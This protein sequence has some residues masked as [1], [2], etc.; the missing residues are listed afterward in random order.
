[1]RLIGEMSLARLGDLIPPTT[2]VA[3][4]LGNQEAVYVGFLIILYS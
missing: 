4:W 2:S 1:M 3:V